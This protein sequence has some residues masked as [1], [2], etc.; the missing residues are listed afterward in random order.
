[1][2][3]PLQAEGLAV[4]R[5]QARRL[6]RQA[7]VTVQR[8]KQRHPVTTASRHGYTVAPTLLVRQFTV[9]KPTQVWVG[10]LTSVGTAEGWW[11][12][13]V[14]L[15]LYARKIVGGAMSQRVAAALVQK[16]LPM[17]LGRRQ[18]AAGVI[19]HADRGSH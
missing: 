12:L 1:M 11:Y 5:D 16:A 8:R 17:A 10:A 2:A 13:G 4:G 18:P 19:H 15:D 14:R 9:E 3:K 7:Q 6:R